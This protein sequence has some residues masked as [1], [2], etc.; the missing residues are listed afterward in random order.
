MGYRIY[1]HQTSLAEAAL[2]YGIHHFSLIESGIWSLWSLKIARDAHIRA[3]RIRTEIGA[4]YSRGC[5]ELSALYLAK[6]ETKHR[7]IETGG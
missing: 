7:R 2:A 5:L 3:E 4:Q 6:N 1:D